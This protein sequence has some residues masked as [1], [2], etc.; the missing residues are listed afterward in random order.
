MSERAVEVVAGVLRATS[1][2]TYEPY[3]I[4]LARDVLY[5]LDR[6]GFTVTA[7]D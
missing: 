5:E 1:W 3:P 7:G 4:A 6:V 2:P